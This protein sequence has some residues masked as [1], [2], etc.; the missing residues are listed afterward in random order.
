MYDAIVLP[1]VM[2]L[3]IALAGVVAG[4]AS[5]PGTLLITVAV[6]GYLVW[7]A[8]WWTMG[9]FFF[10]ATLLLMIAGC[11]SLATSCAQLQERRKQKT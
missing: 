9:N 4:M 2:T 1:T 6:S 11:V 3:L 7:V 8:E 10:A 5:S